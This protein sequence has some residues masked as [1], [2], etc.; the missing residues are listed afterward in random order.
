MGY[1]KTYN[2]EMTRTEAPDYNAITVREQEDEV[3]SARGSSMIWK[4]FVLQI[5]KIRGKNLR[6]RRRASDRSNRRWKLGEEYRRE[7]S[8]TS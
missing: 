8:P 3:E 2:H 5:W 4:I 1:S 7:V 6:P